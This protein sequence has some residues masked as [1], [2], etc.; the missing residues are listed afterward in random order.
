MINI[1]HH[2]G[3]GN[4]LY[5]DYNSKSSFLDDEKYLDKLLVTFGGIFMASTVANSCRVWNCGVKPEV[6]GR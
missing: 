6:I 5:A 3:G 4:A 1:G 2:W